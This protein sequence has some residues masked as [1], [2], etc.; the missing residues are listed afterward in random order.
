MTNCNH[1]AY[2]DFGD[3][4]VAVRCTETGKHERCR[5]EVLIGWDREQ[6]NMVDHARRELE[7]L[8]TS[9]EDISH[10]IR[11]VQA[12]V[13]VGQSGGS[14]SWY[15]PILHDLFQ[16]KNLSPLTDDPRDWIQHAPDVWQNRRNGEAFSCDGGHTYY[17][18]SDEAPEY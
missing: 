5:T 12:F 13:D 4:P 10:V 11:I 17:L 6:S 9:E 8:G 14:A 3:G 7:L 2:V 15:I 16:F 1:G 18:L